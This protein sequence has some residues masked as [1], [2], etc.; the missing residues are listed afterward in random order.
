MATTTLEF[1]ASQG[2]TLSAQLFAFGADV[3]LITAAATEYSV[4]KGAYHCSIVDID[5]GTY[6]LRIKNAAN[7]TI[8]RG[9][10]VHRNVAG[11]VER[12]A[13]IG[14]TY[15]EPGQEEPASDASLAEK[16]NYLYKMAI[17]KKKQTATA[18]QLFDKTGATV[19]Q[20]S[21]VSDDGTTFISGEILSGP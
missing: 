3:A 1:D 12:P 9:L 14:A 13:D 8:A 4:D 7:Q 15:D 21:V 5:S 10:L 18:F 2:L 17:N 6:R 19:D 20:K 11:I 16:I